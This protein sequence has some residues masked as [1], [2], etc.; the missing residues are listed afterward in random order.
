MAAELEVPQGPEGSM[1][2][3][4]ALFQPRLEEDSFRRLLREMLVH[5][6]P[7]SFEDFTRRLKPACDDEFG[8][9]VFSVRRVDRDDGDLLRLARRQAIAS[10]IHLKCSAYVRNNR[11]AGEAFR[12]R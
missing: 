7:G 9:R 3:E 6:R 8:Q 10:I 1:R 11:G 4:R 5:Q 2:A 12:A